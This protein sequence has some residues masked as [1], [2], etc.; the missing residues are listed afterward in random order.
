MATENQNVNV[1]V[2]KSTKSVGI[3]VAL[4]FFFGPLGMLYSTILG[5]IIMFIISLVV[6]IITLG[7]GLI[8]TIPICAIWGGVAAHLH[9][10]KLLSGRA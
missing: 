5:A 9:N 3:A 4:S 1:V 8:V 2:T 6:G 10:K 7:I